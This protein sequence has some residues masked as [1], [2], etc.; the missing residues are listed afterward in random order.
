[1]EPPERLSQRRR[2]LDICTVLALGKAGLEAG[3]LLH[4]GRVTRKGKGKG[5]EKKSLP[6]PPTL[7][8]A[9]DDYGVA[10]DDC[11]DG[12]AGAQT[13]PPPPPAPRTPRTPRSSQVHDYDEASRINDEDGEDRE[14]E[15]AQLGQHEA[16]VAGT[17]VQPLPPPPAAPRTPRYDEHDYDPA[18]SRTY[19]EEGEEREDGCTQL[20]KH[21]L[22]PARR[23][24]TRGTALLST[25]QY[26]H[27]YDPASTER[28]ISPRLR[29]S[30]DDDSD[31]LSGHRNQHRMTTTHLDGSP[32]Y[33]V[34]AET[35]LPGLRSGSEPE[36]PVLRSGSGLAAT[37]GRKLA[38]TRRHSAPT[39]MAADVKT[40]QRQSPN[41]LAMLRVDAANGS[42]G[43]GAVAA[44]SRR[45]SIG[46]WIE[47]WQGLGP[48]PPPP[49]G[50]A[51]LEADEGPAPTPPPRR[52]RRDSNSSH[53]SSA[54]GGSGNTIIGARKPGKPLKQRQCGGR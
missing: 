11:D 21:E 15:C 24:R 35:E 22:A 8:D 4:I 20:G 25:G 23:P 42:R 51:P 1:M 6:S 33:D 49:S 19:D 14:D 37:R 46:S 2:S 47:P 34:P 54:S 5:K 50:P 45:T 41:Q 16:A 28:P 27:D 48:P 44:Q 7:W 13:L 43:A 38:T 53:E 52:R 3:T 26:H 30:L 18:S 36:P 9:G 39:G 17:D 12:G 40:R 32:L 10:G 29:S 31:C